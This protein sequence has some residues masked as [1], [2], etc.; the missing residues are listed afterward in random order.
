MAQ[1]SNIKQFYVIGERVRSSVCDWAHR[2]PQNN[3]AFSARDLAGCC[4]IASYALCKALSAKGFKPEFVCGVESSWG[5]H[6]WV[7]CK[8]YIVDITATQF[9][10]KTPVHIV[11]IKN[12]ENKTGIYNFNVYLRG[13]VALKETLSWE[14]Q[15]AFLFKDKVHSLV[16]TLK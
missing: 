9:G 12:G 6:C 15:N 14:Y 13:K 8:N 4:A 16:R 11:K 3:N 5:S 7:E 1:Q 10:I 2:H